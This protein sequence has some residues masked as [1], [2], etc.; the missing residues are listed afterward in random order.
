MSIDPVLYK[1]VNSELYPG[2]SDQRHCLVFWARP[3]ADVK[4]LVAGLQ[5]KLLDIAP[6]RQTLY[7]WKNTA[8]VPRSVA[9]AHRKPSYDGHGNHV[10][11]YGP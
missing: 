9:Y 1:L 8:Y 6:R 10:L 7:K 5:K 4:V 3:P 2:Y 11:P